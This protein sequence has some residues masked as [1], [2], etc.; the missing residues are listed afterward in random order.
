MLLALPL[1]AQT[2]AFEV[3]SIRPSTAQRSSGAVCRATKPETE[4]VQVVSDTFNLLII[5]AYEKEIDR[6]DL[7]DWGKNGFDVSVKMPRNTSVDT[8]RLML[9]N[10]LAERF[11]LVV[12]IETRQLPSYFLKVAKSGLKLRPVD[13]PPPDLLASS[14]SKTEEGRRH[15]IFRAAPM[16]RVFI[17]VETGV[18]LG[19]RRGLFES[20]FITDETGLTGFYDGELEYEFPSTESPSTQL[21]HAPSLQDALVEQLGLTLEMR[22]APRKIL[23][24]RSSDHMPTEN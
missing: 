8:C 16:S 15:T 2:P 23:S 6:F 13:S 9:R 17:A 11:H 3:A 10:L 14:T 5:E 20:E 12:A 18:V 19:S 21:G 1:A 22:K 4:N 7:P 24:I